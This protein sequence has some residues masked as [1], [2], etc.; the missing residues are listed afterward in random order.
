L[1]RSSLF[2]PSLA[3]SSQGIYSVTMVSHLCSLLS[4]RKWLCFCVYVAYLTLQTKFPISIWALLTGSPRKSHLCYSAFHMPHSKSNI[5]CCL[6]VLIYYLEPQ[7]NI[8]THLPCV[9][10]I[11]R[12]YCILLQAS[13]TRLEPL[14]KLTKYQKNFNLSKYVILIII[15]TSL[16]CFLQKSMT[17]VFDVDIFML[18]S[19]TRLVENQLSHPL[20]WILVF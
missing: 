2:G 3:F 4:F 14:I 16:S 8:L 12:F 18:Y 13:R 11:H 5:H 7:Q 17:L 19:S 20:F 15:L 10:L 9:R 1:I 6:V